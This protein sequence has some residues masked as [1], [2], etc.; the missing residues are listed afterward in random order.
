[1]AA[2]QALRSV[3]S[4]VETVIHSALNRLH[5]VL[6]RSDRATRIAVLM[7][8]QCGQVVRYHLSGADDITESGEELLI[9]TIAGRCR[10]VIDVGA[11]N[12][13]WISRFLSA[14]TDTGIRGLVFEPQRRCLPQLEAK[15][16]MFPN[17]E[18]INAAVGD[19][20]QEQEFFEAEETQHSS[21]IEPIE[22]ATGATY[23]VVV[24]TIDEEVV[25]RGWDT[26]DY[27]KVDA[28]GYDLRALQGAET[29]L[30]EGRIGVIQFEYNRAWSR[31]GSTLAAAY[32]YLNSNGYAVFLLKAEGLFELCY[33]RYGEFFAYTNFCAVATDHIGPLKS[34]LRGPI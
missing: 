11:H 15:L 7:R 12:G 32:S 24:T 4:G 5:R 10:T 14:S 3:T 6:G 16:S 27:L 1:M 34:L 2:Q 30:G 17:V 31:A 18:I 22:E 21:L 28:E 25:R 29:L 26:V 8:N 19:R 23:P 20:H 13:L 33:A 9:Q